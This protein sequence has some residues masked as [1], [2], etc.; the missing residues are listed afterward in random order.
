M[1]SSANNNPITKTKVLIFL[2]IMKT[3]LK[4]TGVKEASKYFFYPYKIDKT[5]F[6]LILRNHCC[7]YNLYFFSGSFGKPDFFRFSFAFFNLLGKR[8]ML[9]YLSSEGPMRTAGTFLSFISI[10]VFKYK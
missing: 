9:S 3:Q 5:Y 4:K 8:T 7:Y 10:M 1:I 2:R 6:L